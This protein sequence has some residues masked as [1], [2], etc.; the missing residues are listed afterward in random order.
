MAI[1]L[2]DR[3]AILVAFRR[4]LGMGDVE[5]CSLRAENY[6]RMQHFVCRTTYVPFWRFWGYVRLEFMQRLSAA[7]HG[8][9]SS[10]LRDALHEDGVDVMACLHV[11]RA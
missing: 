7:L 2:V 10:Y 8:T 4:F 5:S 1:E 11:P 3:L 6:G 9:L